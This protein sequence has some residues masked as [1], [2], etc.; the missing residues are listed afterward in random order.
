MLTTVRKELLSSPAIGARID[1]VFPITDLAASLPSCLAASP[2]ANSSNKQAT[3][4]FSRLPPPRRL[5]LIPFAFIFPLFLINILHILPYFQTNFNSFTSKQIISSDISFKTLC[6]FKI[7]SFLQ[8][9][10]LY[11]EISLSI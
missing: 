2:A 4:A 10:F 3:R 5:F 11:K 1:S 7:Y 8:S 6:K 9:P